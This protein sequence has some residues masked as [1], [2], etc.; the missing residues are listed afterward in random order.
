MSI[1]IAHEEKRKPSTGHYFPWMV[2]VKGNGI[3]GQCVPFNGAI[4]LELDG[5]PFDFNKQ[6]DLK[7]AY[8]QAE[9]IIERNSMLAEAEEMEG[10]VNRRGFH[11]AI[12]KEMEAKNDSVY[13]EG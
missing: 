3:N 12:N 5:V 4:G 9:Q 11:Q 1:T 8:V 10:D 13:S 7:R 2:V 6:D